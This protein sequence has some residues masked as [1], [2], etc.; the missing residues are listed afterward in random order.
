MTKRINKLVDSLVSCKVFA[1][2]GCDHGYVSKEMLKQG[3][4]ER[5]VISDISEKCLKKAEDLLIDYIR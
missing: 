3:K 2:I 5:V 4:C 1:D